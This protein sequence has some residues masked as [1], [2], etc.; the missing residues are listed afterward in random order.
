[1]AETF[2]EKAAS[3]PPS[4]KFVSELNYED[5]ADREEMHQRVFGR[6]YTRD[7]KGNPIELSAMTPER[8]K[9]FPDRAEQHCQAVGKMEGPVMELRERTRLGR[10]IGD[11]LIERA[12]IAEAKR[13][14]VL[15]ELGLPANVPR[16][17][18][19]QF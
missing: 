19:D 18:T 2:S 8:A 10:P 12:A 7:A 11:A 15:T 9:R 3:L 5:P 4:S 6:G 13:K 17:L 1:M 14:K 16:E